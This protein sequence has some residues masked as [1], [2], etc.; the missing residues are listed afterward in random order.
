MTKETFLRLECIRCG[1]TV[2]DSYFS[3]GCPHCASH[4]IAS[5]LTTVYNLE[6]SLAAFAEEALLRKP[7]GMWR[8]DAFLPFAAE[9]AVTLGEG[10]T[11]LVSV[12]QLARHLGL[13]ALWVKDESRNPT[14]S[15]KDRSAAVGATHALALGSPAIVVSST[16]NAA[17]ATAAYAR[18]AGLP[19]VVLFAK[20]VDPIMSAFVRSYGALAVATPT[21][22][23][24]WE[25]MKTCIN[26]WGFYPAGNYQR[27]PVGLNPF[28]L[29]GYQ[30]IGFEI[31][32]QLG[33]RAPDWI[34][35]P[36][37]ESNCLYGL[38]KSFSQLEALGIATVPR[39]GAAEI[40]G[41]LSKAIEEQ[42]EILPLMST[43]QP[44][45]AFSIATAQNT[46]Q[47]LEAIRRSYGSATVLQ[48]DEI[49]NAQKLLVETEGIFSE[50]TSGAALAALMHRLRTGEIDPDSEA[51]VV[52]TSSG[53]KSLNVTR[54]WND[55]IP[56][57]TNRQE[58][59][60][61]L[62][63]QYGFFPEARKEK[64]E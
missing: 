6:R 18:R 15:F 52:M 16:G 34:F 32:E 1:M 58:L 11:A 19:V 2:D 24:R 35:A 50:A 42:A 60:D 62:N 28:M 17:A 9:E 23:H 43:D 12:P 45:V 38:F 13:R 41:S 30:T 63:N 55:E 64:A 14:W 20:G 7:R 56:I 47:G 44:T 4:D 29:D 10:G 46:F 31:W 51:V 40:Y 57:A 37:G 22:P 49:L 54:P 26:E 25:L 8:Y 33:R 39:L 27:P 5:N 59:V 3:I 61:I 36:V 48:N 53:L 21:K